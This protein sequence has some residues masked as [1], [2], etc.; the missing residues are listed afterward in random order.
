MNITGCSILNFGQC[1]LWLD[2][3][4]T[5][6]VSDCLIH[7][8]QPIEGSVSLRATGSR[9]NMIVE[10]LLGNPPN[11]NES[12]GEVKG[13]YLAEDKPNALPLQMK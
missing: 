11:V 4:T 1:G 5:S 13:N 2:E 10:N 3:V 12:V 7:T 8:D 9:G 6:R